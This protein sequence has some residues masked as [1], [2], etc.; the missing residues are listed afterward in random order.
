MGGECM[1][2]RRRVFLTA[3]AAL[4]FPTHTSATTNVTWNGG[5]GS[6][7]LASGW[8]TG[9]VPND[10]TPAGATYAVQVD[11]LPGTASNVTLGIGLNISLTSLR[12]DAGDLVRTS[13]STLTLADLTNAGTITAGT[14]TFTGSLLFSGSAITLQGGGTISLAKGV[15]GGVSSS[16]PI[17]LTNFDQ[18]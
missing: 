8:S 10:G 3:I 18:T 12:I 5:A 15:L 1:I 9:A 14:G 7:S 11:N 17:A 13:G 16:T 4:S 2:L 6:W